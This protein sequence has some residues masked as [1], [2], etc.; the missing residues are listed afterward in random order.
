V[1]KKLL[2]LSENKNANKNHSSLGI[3][4]KVTNV[5]KEENFSEK[6]EKNTKMLRQLIVI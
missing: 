1:F 6:D 3:I 2:A 4:K 5:S